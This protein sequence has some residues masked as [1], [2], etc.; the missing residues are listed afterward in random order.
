MIIKKTAC[1][2]IHIE[3][4]NDVEKLLF[5]LSKNTELL[6]SFFHQHLENFS[7]HIRKKKI[8]RDKF[9]FKKIKP[10]SVLGFFVLIAFQFQYVIAQPLNALPING[11]VV[12]GVAT[13][14]QTSTAT[15]ATMTVNQTSQR[16]VINWDSFNVGKNAA[17]NFVT[18]GANSSTLNRVT[19]ASPSLIQGAL[20]SNGQIILVNANGITFGRG[21]QVDAPGVVASTMD[22]ANK[23][24]MDGKSTFSGSG[25]GKIVNKGTISA[26]TQDGFIALLAPEVQNQGYL[27]ASKGG[28]VVMTAGEQITLNFQG[29][30]LGG[31]NVD[32][33]TYKALVANKRVVEVNGGLVVMA[34]GAANQLMSSVIKNTGRVSASSVVNN[35]G[36]IEFVGN[37]VTQAGTVEANSTTGVGGQVNLVGNNI[38]ATSKSKTTAT[39]AT[40]GGQVNM[41]LAQTAVSGGTQVNAVTP[42]ANTV[43]INQAIVKANATQ[44]A[45]NNSLAQTVTVEQGASIDASATQSGNGGIIAIWSALKTN[46]AGSLKAIGGAVS[47]NGGFVETSSK[48]TVILAPN[49]I[50]NTS[51]SN[52]K[53][54]TWL[55][56]PID[57]TI[58]AATANIISA[59][60]ENN[61]V[62][63]AVNGNVCPSLGSCTQ[64]GSGSLTIA[65]GTNILKATGS[66]ST[67]SLSSS[68]VFNL[69][70]NISGQNLNV[71]ISSSI[72][73]LNAGS[74]ITANQV[75]VQAQTIYANGIINAQSGTTLG[76]AIQ[77]LAQ[78]IYVSGGLNTS[79]SSNTN[80]SNTTNT[81]VT[82]N[83]NIIRKEDLPTFLTSQNNPNGNIAGGLDVVYTSSAANDSS[84]SAQTNT[85]QTN[86]IHLN[87]VNDLTIYS[88][89]QIL[90][91]GTNGGQITLSAQQLNAQSGSLIQ[92]NGNNGPGGVIAING[93]DI[94][95]AGAVA[96]NGSNGGSFAVTANTLTIDSAAV[97]QTNGQAGPGGTITLTSHQDIQINQA[98]ISANG[99]TDGG[100]ITI[101]SNAGN[102]N[103][104]NTLIQTNGSNG[105]GGSIGISTFNQTILSG[106]TV[107]ASGF[108]QGGTILIGN[109]ANNS[110]LPFSIYTSLDALT[111]IN[112][113]Q[114]NLSNTTAGGLV[115]TSGATLSMLASINA[116]RGGM[117]LIDPY[118]YIIGSTEAGYINTALNAGTAVTINATNA[119]TSVGSNSISGSGPT[120]AIVINGLISAS[121]GTAALSLTATTIYINNNVTTMG[122]QTYTGNVVLGMPSIVLQTSNA[123]VTVTG[124]IT[125]QPTVLEFLGNT[126]Y[127]FNAITYSASSSASSLGMLGSISWSGT[128]YTFTPSS[129][130]TLSSVS[131]LLVAGG[132]SGGA[133]S[134]GGYEGG[135]GGGGGG[136]ASGTMQLTANTNYVVTVGA[137]GISS[138]STTN[139][140][141]NGG[142]T[143]ITGGATITVY[144]GG[145]GGEGNGG[146]SSTGISGG[147]GGGGNGYGGTHNPG[148]VTSCFGCPSGLTSYGN[149]GGTGMNGVGGGNGGGGGATAVG[150]SAN[151]STASNGGAGLTTDITGSS[152]VYGSGGGAGAGDIPHMNNGNQGSGGSNAGNGGTGGSNG[153]GGS[154]GGNAA[155]NYGGGG[156]GA[157]GMTNQ[158]G[159]TGGSGIAVFK[160]ST[161]SG[162][163]ITTGSGAVSLAAVTGLSRLTIN[164]TSNASQVTGII[165]GSGSVALN[166]ASGYNSGVL[167]F[168]GANTYTGGTTISGGTLQV[169]AGSTTGN[170]GTGGVTDN[171]ALI[172][173]R[174]DAITDANNI[175]GSGTLT[176]AGSGTLTLSGN[177]SYTGGTTISGGTLQV[178]AGST[179]GNL[180]TG[181]V[182]DNAALIFNR[183]DAI[184]DANNITGSGTLTQAGSGTLT[185]SGNNSYTG[186][187][188]LNAGT[189]NLGS[190]NAI[191]STG[192]ITFGNYSGRITGGGILQFSSSNTTDYSSR[193]SSALFQTYLID[194][195]G[196]SV[197]L[198]SALTSNVGTLIKLGSGT[199]TLG[200]TNTYANGSGT[201][202]YG[203][204]L[205]VS[206][207]ANL[208][209][210]SPVMLIGGA[211]LA[212]SSFSTS[213]NI[214]AY[215][216]NGVIEAASGV[217]LTLTGSIDGTTVNIGGTATGGSYT[218]T[219]VYAPS[220]GS[221]T[222]LNLYAG[223]L[224][225]NSSYTNG[226]LLTIYGGNIAAAAGTTVTFSN[227]VAGS[228]AINIG[229]SVNTGTVVLS[230]TSNSFSGGVN[231]NY[232]TLSVSAQTNL[233]SGNT[234]TL[235]NG[236]TLLDTANS[237]TLANNIVL[238]TGGGV[239]AV[240]GSANTLTLSGT[241]TGANAIQFGTSTNTGT[242]ALTTNKAFTGAMTVSAA[243]VNLSGLLSTTTIGIS[244]NGTLAVTGGGYNRINLASVITISNGTFANTQ[245]G[246]G[247]IGQTMA[248]GS[249]LNLNGNATV[250]LAGVGDTWGSISVQGLTINSTGSGNTIT[251]GALAIYNTG[252]TISVASATSLTISSLMENSNSTAGLFTKIG[253]GTLIL[254]GANTYTGGTTIS[255]GTIQVGTGGTTGNLGTGGVAINNNSALVYNRSDALTDNNIISG[256]GTVTQNGSGTT[257]LGG[258]NTYT[259]ITTVNT[260]TL[261]NTASGSSTRTVTFNI[262]SGGTYKLLSTVGFPQATTNGYTFVVNSGGTLDL[263]G[264]GWLDVGSTGYAIQLNGGS[265]SN[266]SATAATVTMSYS[267]TKDI[268][269]AAN[270]YIG[271]TGNITL[272]GVIS[273]AYSLTNSN[274]GVVTLGGANTYS[275]GTFI[276]A[277]TVQISSDGNLGA[278]PSSAATN[279][280]ING[281]GLLASG[282]TGAFSISANRGIAIGSSGGSISN[283]STSYTLTVAGVI[284]GSNTL[285]INAGSN[286]GTVILS[287]AANSY[288]GN[289]TINGGTLQIGSS[290]TLGSG[291]YAGN[292]SIATGATFKYSSSAAQTLSGAISGVGT[293]TK[294]TGTSVLT[295][296]NANALFAG[297]VNA[298][299]GTLALS[300]P[301]AL[302]GSTGGL[303]TIGA[304]G[305]VDLQYAGT[306]TLATLS[307]ASGGA[308]TN[309][310]AN[311]ALTVSG[312]STL[313]GSV[314]TNAL[315]TYTGAVILGANTVLTTTTA[316]ITFSSTVDSVV[317]SNYSLTITNGS[318]SNTFAGVVGGTTPLSTISV[319]GASSLLSSVTTSGASGQLWSGNLTI[320]G[321]VTLSS[322]NGPVTI[323]GAVTSLQLQNILQFTGSGAY[324]DTVNGVV[325]TG[326][327]GS[328]AIT[329]PSGGGTLS[330]A[331]GTGIYSWTAPANI[332]AQYLVV[333]G[334]GAGGANDGGGG[335]GGGVLAG[336]ISSSSAVTF[337]AVVGAGGSGIVSYPYVGNSGVNST[338]NQSSLALNITAV[339]GGGGGGV[340]TNTAGSSGGSGGGGGVGGVGGSATASQ[341]NTGG[342]GSPSP[343]AAGGGG[344]AGG[345][346]GVGARSTFNDIT[347][348]SAL[349][350]AGGDGLASSITGTTVYYGAGG[351]GGS[352]AFGGSGGLGGG[353]NGGTNV[354]VGG[355]NNGI[356]SAGSGY[357]SG[358]GGSQV[359]TTVGGSG[360]SGV[361]ILS[362]S[363]SNAFTINAGSGKVALAGNINSA[364]ANS[365]SLKSIAITSSNA[366]SIISGNI[367]G[368]S[369]FTFNGSG[370]LQLTGAN[371]Y[372]GGTTISGGTL[373]IASAGAGGS[374]LSTG[375][376]TIGGGTLLDTATSTINN[377]IT[378]AAGTNKIAAAALTTLTISSIIG[379]GANSIVFG[380]S[381]NTGT[382]ILSAANTYTGGTTISGGTVQVG[383]GG[384]TGSLGTGGVVNNAALVYNVSAAITDA[385]II[386]GTG[387]ITQSGSGALTLTSNNTYTGLTTVNSGTVLYLTPSGTF[388]DTLSG[389]FVNNGTINFDGSNGLGTATGSSGTFIY[390]ASGSGAWNITN[391]IANTTQWNNRLVIYGVVTTSG[392][393]TVNNYG[394]FWL[395]ASTTSSVNSTSAVNLNGAN[396]YLRVYGVANAID[397]IGAL[398]GSGTVDFSDGGAGTS[399]ALS[400]GNGNGSGTFTGAIKNSG[401][402][403][404]PTTLGLTK[405]GTGTQTL[406]GT[407]TYTGA[408]TI[409]G[410]ILSV[411]TLANGGTSSGIGQS[412]SSAAN[413]VINSG[414]L[415]YTG[416]TS[417]QTLTT[418][419]LFTIG[420]SGA[421]ID[422]SGTGALTFGNSGSIAFSS[423]TSTPTLTLT[424]NG[425]ATL[426]PIL[427]NAGT[428][429]YIT[430]LTKTSSGTWTL[431]GADTYSGGTT[432][433]AGT[434]SAASG[435]A[436]G[437]GAVGIGSSGTLNLSYGGTV[438]LGSNLSM[439]A[440]SSITNTANTSN[441]TVTGTG[442]LAGT[443]NTA[444]YQ[445]YTGAVTLGANTT[446]STLNTS[447]VNTNG[448]ISFIAAVNGT[449]GTETLTVANGSGNLTFGSTVGASTVLGSLTVNGVSGSP[450]LQTTLLLG[451]ITTTGIQSYGGNL[452]LSANIA[453][454]TTNS[455]VTV[456]GIVYQKAILQFL[457]GVNGSSSSGGYS[458]S[459]DGGNTFVSGTATSTSTSIVGVGAI[460][461]SNSAYSFTPTITASS[462]Y[463]VVGGGG[464]GGSQ[465]GGGG[466]AGGVLQSSSTFVGG[467][468]YSITVGSGG[469]IAA[470]AGG[471]GN[472]TTISGG[473]ITTITAYGGGGGGS[474]VG[475]S[476]AP[477][478]GGSG[479]GAANLTTGL[480]GTGTLNQ[481][482]A[483]GGT[484]A[485]SSPIWTTG[486][487]GGAG[488]VGVAGN[489]TSAGAGGTGVLNS[490]AG[491][492]VGQQSNGSYYVGG[493]GGGGNY[494]NLGSN[495][496]NGVG[497]LGGGGAGAVNT[498]TATSGSSNTGGGGGGGSQNF[499]LTN[500]GAGGSGVVVLS[501]GSSASNYSL[502]I[503]GGSGAVTIGGSLY[504]LAGVNINSTS[505]TSAISGAIT[506]PTALTFNNAINYTGSNGGVLALSAANTYAGNTTIGGGTLSLSSAGNLG[507]GSYAGTITIGSGAVFKDASS[508]AQT[509]SGSISGA[510]SIVKDTSTSTL[511]LTNANTLTGGITINAGTLQIGN[512]AAS[513][514]TSI[515]NNAITIAAGAALDLNGQ[516]TNAYSSLT[517]NGS[518]IN[519]A[520]A[521]TNSASGSASYA[522][523]VTLNTASAIGSGTGAIT[524][525]GAIT[526]TNNSGLALIG[527][528]A[529]T[530]SSASNA[531]Y[532]VASTTASSGVGAISIIN[533]AALIIG[534][535][536]VG[537][538]TY[539]GLKSS[540]NIS[541]QTLTGNLTIAQSV[542]S[543]S[544]S[545]SASA[546]TLLFAAAKNAAVGDTT[547]NII[548]SGSPSITMSG[549][550]AIADFYSGSSTSSTGLAT[551]INAKTTNSTQSGVTTS[552]QPNTAGFN[553]LFRENVIYIAVSGTSAYGS[554]AAITYKEC[555]NLSCS[556]LVASPPT[557]TGTVSWLETVPTSSSNVGSYTLTYGSGLSATGYVLR[558]ATAQAYIITAANL[559]ITANNQNAT[560]GTALTVGSGST[561]FA[562]SGLKNSETI[563]SI[564]LA[565]TGASNTASVGSY[566]IVP[567]AAT[568]GTFT[569]SNY[570]ITYNNGT[571]TVVARPIIITASS[572]QTKVYGEANPTLNYSVEANGSGRGLFGSDTFTGALARATGENVGSYTIGQG[573]LANNNYAITF[574][575]SNFSITARPIYISANASQTKVYGNANPTLT[576][577]TQVKATGSG[578]LGTDNVTLSGSLA[579]ASGEDVG[580]AYAISQGTVTTGS[581]NY[582]IV[583]TGANFAITP[584]PITLTA[585]SATKIYGE[586][587]PSLAVTITAGS[588]ASAAVTDTL[589]NVTGTLS[590]SAGENVGNY[591]ILLGSGTKAANYTITFDSTN[592]AMGITARPIYI[593]ANASQTKVYGNANPTLTYTTQVKATGSGL[594]GTDNVTLSGS[595]ARASG[596]DVGS[597]YAISQGTV[598]TGSNNYSIVYTGANFA[599]TPR[600]ITLTASSAT[601]IYGETDPSLAVTI[602]AGSLASAA[603]TDT[604]AN[605]TGT[606]SRSAGE[607]VGNYNILLGSGTKAANYTITFDS[608][609]QAMGITARP[610]YISA[611]ASQTKVYG[612]TDPNTYTYTVEAN[613]TSRGLVGSDT[614]TGSLTRATGENV[615]N[616]AIGQGTVANS[617]YAITYVPANFAITPATLSLTG[618]RQYDGTIVMN[619]SA[620]SVAGVNGESF[621]VTGSANLSTKNVVFAINNPTDQT[622]PVA[623]N[624]LDVNGLTLTPVGNALLS[625]YNSLTPI[626]TQVIVTKRSVTL[627]APSISKVY[628]GVSSY[629]MT[630]LDLAA[631]SNRLVG[632]DTVT[633]ASVVFAG[634][635]ANV[636]SGKT[637]NLLSA[638]INDGN[639][640]LNY[641]KSLTSSSTS[642]ITPAQLIVTAVNSAKF[643]TQSDP[644]NFAGAIYNGFV[645]AENASN[646]TGVLSVTRPIGEAA[647][648][649]ILTPS[650]F[651]ASG[652]VNGNYQISYRTGTFTIVPANQLLVEVAPTVVSYGAS[653]IPFSASA[654]YLR[655]SLADCS[656]T[657]SVN[658]VTTLT[659]T[660]NGSSVAISDGVC[661]SANFT[662]IPLAAAQSGSGAYAVGGY[663]LGASNI[664]INGSNFTS[665]VITGGLTIER[666]VLSTS[667]LG[668]AGAQKVYDGN[669][670]ITGLTLPTS[671]TSSS[672]LA[673][674]HVVIGGS[675]YYADQ[676]VGSNKT[677]TLNISLSGADANNYRLSNSQFTDSTGT[678]TQ[679]PS[680]TYLGA[681]GGNWSNAGNW[682]GGAIPTSTTQVIG[683]V[684]TLVNNVAQVIIPS[685]VT[686]NY[687]SALVGQVGSAISNSGNI[688]FNG[689][690]AFN[691]TNQVSG[692]GTI[693]Q[694]GAGTLTISGDNTNRSGNTLISNGTTLM[695]GSLSALGSGSVVSSGGSLGVTGNLVLNSLTTTGP[696]TLVTNIH[697]ANNQIYNGPVTLGAGASV[698]GVITPMLLKSD[699]GNISFNGQLL[700]GA[701]SFANKQSLDIEA[702]NG[703][704]TF[705]DTV[706]GSV[707]NPDGSHISYS[708]AYF[709]SPNI[710][711][712]N[713]TAN[714]ILIKAN[715]TTFGT[716][717]YTGNV[718][719]GDNGSN[720]STRVLLSEDPSIVIVGTVNDIAPPPNAHNLVIEAITTVAN[721][722]PIV[723]VSSAIIGRIDPLASLTIKTGYQNQDTSLPN[724]PAIAD[725]SVSRGRIATGEV[726]TYGKQIYTTDTTTNS[727]L[728]REINAQNIPQGVLNDRMALEGLASGTLMAAISASKDLD[729]ALTNSKGPSGA[730][731]VTSP[732]ESCQVGDDS[733]LKPKAI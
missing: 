525:T 715:I 172:F 350:G 182:T 723:D 539:T 456:S 113:S 528:N 199:L 645:G 459:L 712:L 32:I 447:A 208:G 155:S 727:G 8:I 592:Q 119:S 232:G 583:Y 87:A 604:L 212:S 380:D 598:T 425:T 39:G 329:L 30:H 463:L 394:N 287:N 575:A 178:G 267:P 623:Q 304:A 500:G 675:G 493:G 216:T 27:L 711:N 186:G 237:V 166:S 318:G 580:S 695:I 677:V 108:I 513:G 24:F 699:N 76:A 438:T 63:I 416:G 251:G 571:L 248:A 407:S 386:S 427:G 334:G 417:G 310:T 2:Y 118:T 355:T 143:T 9:S 378:L 79:T 283:A 509:I 686:V 316:P 258:G 336:N 595:L 45:Q 519:N 545:G 70:A 514:G 591:N 165:S 449:A 214:I 184:T 412:T 684:S 50:I 125:T 160:F 661:G 111:T 168:T 147:S 303:L 211:L 619:G 552:T 679:L 276:N 550:G 588:L 709:D 656:A 568:G 202:I 599:I 396:T 69:N 464:A 515:N 333:A 74:S 611:D 191:G 247:G 140:C 581:N 374:N 339:G 512:A 637:V 680:V 370:T 469:T 366:A 357:G 123:G 75:T 651:G 362:Y 104:Q 725:T 385:N 161:T 473:L 298:N 29:K 95:L 240:N 242:I 652:S 446:L 328:S 42:S 291:S 180:G 478:N 419:R 308:I 465:F 703:Q 133:V 15:N 253:A 576:Y 479:G 556:I 496:T 713:V 453:L 659:P 266:S 506:G 402:S 457:G 726:T 533:N 444:G 490:I 83:G 235:T 128:N 224:L 472:N 578:L 141:C 217:T 289:T 690:N 353:G 535:V 177:N 175:T 148:V 554:A 466:G 102:L 358:G 229:D 10:K 460:S 282:Q 43:A 676:N 650:G 560:Y 163:T 71:I 423:G 296:S 382:V 115:E 574:V 413:L 570:N 618:T 335:G 434:L 707:I 551:F 517:L 492:N 491:S 467:T 431:G 639:N 144:G 220:G 375:T 441:L 662:L 326:T 542:A 196:Q 474:N 349:G 19:G 558:A 17:V 577:T 614:F 338:L 694:S 345:A 346:G 379:G 57:L 562:S 531:L 435:N 683:G 704:V 536:T 109:D 59:A 728:H 403:S 60:L 153:N 377:P 344:G 228:A 21:A 710:Y 203:G 410:G 157:G 624:L 505:A 720:G 210:S 188:I 642:E 324:S 152:A 461:Y 195:N 231:V 158:F 360:S 288:S 299:A 521:L 439:V 294:D 615:G 451:N 117:W 714:T 307:I 544:A 192:T 646:L 65:S 55:L 376:V 404:G 193:F 392:Q 495:S 418:D 219:I 317:G 28:T 280:T 92:A 277:G 363:P 127:L 693:T 586:T 678:I 634:S 603:V 630:A 696:I 169:G 644:V 681:T 234:V 265:L 689:S 312:T 600:P 270:S 442:T 261:T 48:G 13:I 365:N 671:A 641:N 284:S 105:R 330:Y 411:A 38:T 226:S 268:V 352:G 408:T 606:L 494:N 25:S 626:N 387:S 170:L 601:K 669:A 198:G 388:A 700:G 698:N 114:T 567:S 187:T 297:P 443:I 99:Y 582:S 424:G 526:D 369:S 622:A 98:Q 688:L 455:N 11:K 206:S 68:G 244:G 638:T 401:A 101:V 78:A 691:F 223:T 325:A 132:G 286:T 52:G 167:L 395:Q 546:P 422:A 46:I 627:T 487:G 256:T 351:G 660:I 398:T 285:T 243:T 670:A 205:Q 53:A 682:A 77:L 343:T 508:V 503:T 341:G 579:R 607:N 436:L 667:Q 295:I 553:A 33:A 628:D 687:D 269:L 264:V 430:A 146:G 481:G 566:N 222:N 477:K 548:L 313:G 273:G 511:A 171:A 311:S 421:T 484:T 274:T 302:G 23:D 730:I 332:I 120:S 621:N 497:G 719:I 452:N 246:T 134:N 135:G 292:I 20:S 233:P 97:V 657:G 340:G 293:L 673:N 16:A 154:A 194:T 323:N 697:T 448:A 636:G 62:S 716:Q 405:V 538:N 643:V 257:T 82:Y 263:N 440:G 633:A 629:D 138:F 305:T 721:E 41:G 122:S 129:S 648:T 482:N 613:G 112:A 306:V 527:N 361:V 589:A 504:V 245:I 86:I 625:N 151:G 96:A 139:A 90:A 51:A 649:F 1:Q 414:T 107:E 354:N 47:G 717:N 56:D 488:S 81:S 275:G 391:S 331:S 252:L 724:P 597:A 502:T 201:Q 572:G 80:T 93:T 540:G 290:G 319:S 239:V 281:G 702:L 616:Y 225:N 658:T 635:N 183:S 337:T 91:N 381:T 84:A 674:D 106:A 426:T 665:M 529:L 190:A 14:S 301:S 185:L 348:G 260:G 37:T 4:Q 12:A 584:R 131:T 116:G 36:E 110:T 433:S 668:I 315:Q 632:G 322:N 722:T 389:G 718:L 450:Y 666:L 176:Q 272:N 532:Q 130:L 72:A 501:I 620:M 530:L 64:N 35:G 371:T 227:T 238:G 663:N 631:M 31:V 706:G 215:L 250:S 610:I 85:N 561:Q 179:T 520:G 364:T 664:A 732:D 241:M 543:S 485:S 415:Q 399:M 88:S 34:A 384:A 136:V 429:T 471:N 409:S 5:I 162:L 708:S 149:N 368:S 470:G 249:Q 100:S 672:V 209:N 271:G 367:Y 701:S 314:T 254:T 605:V 445:T 218:G 278:V 300:N 499:S 137:G 18:P 103:I 327:A 454:A 647:G 6:I 547:Y 541:V 428:S 54:G 537:A 126:S 549:T 685:G 733:C 347:S 564:T 705:G 516:T 49:A 67:L 156:G 320:A 142:N 181:G 255:A 44:A 309:S 204:I 608:T 207:D 406:S 58:D 437:V 26:T 480:A 486:G 569:A 213:K 94:R 557:V 587:D 89:A 400:V 150:T 121:S 655:C 200:A 230:N 173:N 654:R 356:G 61:N 458:Y 475:G 523:S 145:A 602:T 189:L 390:G 468:A 518:G 692:S 383:A 236:G 617:N 342:A 321:N 594:L 489:T 731:S 596:E 373:S 573:T 73:Y 593:S 372:T 124:S 420:A 522:G 164:S 590:R 609:N 565:S 563:G 397:A 174:S 359:T 262:N 393:I 40:G 559:S 22:I 3:L 640:G 555:S 483:G 159:G 432:I 524:I 66:L 729:F 476:T 462:N 259:G 221:L 534:S 510:G 197:T 279:V 7:E 612:N 585:S 498:A 653:T 507:G